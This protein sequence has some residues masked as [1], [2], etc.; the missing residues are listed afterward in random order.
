MTTAVSRTD[1]L[2]AL[3]LADKV[4]D[5]KG[6]YAAAWC[7]IAAK[8]GV[9]TIK[10]TDEDQCAR[11]TL[12]CKGD[13]LEPVCVDVREVL[14][15]YPVAGG[16]ETHLYVNENGALMIGGVGYH[17]QSIDP[18]DPLLTFAKPE[19][20]QCAAT[21]LAKDWLDNLS[22]ISPCMSKEAERYYLNG[23]VIRSGAPGKDSFDKEGN[24]LPGPYL[25]FAAT[26]GHRLAAL[27]VYIGEN[28]IGGDH[29][30]PSKAI[31][32]LLHLLRRAPREALVTFRFGQGLMRALIDG[33][34]YVTKLVNGAYPDYGRVIPAERVHAKTAHVN[35]CALVAAARNIANSEANA[36][37]DMAVLLQKSD[38]WLVCDANGSTYA[39]FADQTTEDPLVIGF[40]TKYLQDLAKTFAKG[41]MLKLEMGTPIDPVLITS[42]SNPGMRYV[43]MPCRV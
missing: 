28:T 30:I 34:E 7:K 20:T 26:D 33:V 14:S 11:T 8:D 25:S 31:K 37:P 42:D 6:F 21:M 23:V 38:T 16:R 40:K 9:I 18:F 3:K 35:L 27:D 41:S 22:Q 36:Q 29:I 15:A 12:A 4:S 32:N 2:Q 10:S 5:R 39:A 1:L 19:T 17:P 43:L 24:R 13:D